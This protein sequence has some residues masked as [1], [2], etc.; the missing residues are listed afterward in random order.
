M[1]LG[2]ENIQPVILGLFFI[3]L[4]IL[5]SE[6]EI[7]FPILIIFLIMASLLIYS[8]GISSEIE[9]YLFRLLLISI[10]TIR[11]SVSLIDSKNFY[12]PL[13]FLSVICS[14]LLSYNYCKTPSKLISMIT[15]IFS[16]L[17][18]VKIEYNQI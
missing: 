15:L 14:I 7:Q 5:K 18:F 16:L 1:K 12:L 17:S 11:T 3:M 9:L 4:I 6:L 13:V 10:L 2:S 8:L